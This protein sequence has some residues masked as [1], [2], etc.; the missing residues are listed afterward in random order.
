MESSGSSFGRV[1]EKLP[2]ISS[3]DKR[4]RDKPR[5]GF[6]VFVDTEK[7]VV[8]IKWV[9][10]SG[11]A[12][13]VPITNAGQGPTTFFG[14]MPEV[15]S[16]VSVGWLETSTGSDKF[17]PYI[18]KYWP[19]QA[20][21]GLRN[22]IVGA[23]NPDDAD[24]ET[25]RSMDK[26]FETKRYRRVRI[27]E[28]SVVASSSSGSDVIL[29]EDVGIQDSS[30]CELRIRASDKSVLM[31]S[32][33]KIT[34]TSGTYTKSGPVQRNSLLYAEDGQVTAT[35]QD[36]DG[37][38]VA[39]VNN[40]SILN[41]VVGGDG[42]QIQYVTANRMGVPGLSPVLTEHRTEL[43]RTNDLTIPVRG[44]LDVAE[45][46][47]NAPDIELVH[48]TVV[49]NDHRT[50]KGRK[51]YAR[52]LKPVLWDNDP[53]PGAA[54]PR[55]DPVN[56]LD[57]EEGETA[58]R[59]AAYL[60]RLKRDDGK[61]VLH[62]IDWEGKHFIHI[63][64]PSAAASG[65]SMDINA[66]GG[67]MATVGVDVESR[68]VGLRT[69]GSVE[70]SSGK[71]G[72]VGDSINL[73]G[74]GSININTIASKDGVGWRQ[75]TAGSVSTTVRG[76]VVESCSGSRTIEC[77]TLNFKASKVTY[78]S[79]NDQA[80]TVSGD[81]DRTVVGAVGDRIGGNRSTIIA[82]VN[83]TR[84]NPQAD[85]LRILLGNKETTLVAGAHMTNVTTGSVMTNVGAGPITETI[86]AGAYTI[87]V[88]TGS[89]SI[90]VGAGPITMTSGGPTAITSGGPATVTAPITTILSPQVLVG[91][92]A[93]FGGVLGG[94]KGVG[95]HLDYITGS[96]LRG[97]AIVR[98]AG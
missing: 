44:D 10:V 11:S 53:M 42:R 15:G 76:D 77:N 1:G 46:E 34:A 4:V 69:E 8:N 2:V 33:S 85:A 20:A 71:G 5:L 84:P 75:T 89:C 36:S 40:P 50:N 18:D 13:G 56:V 61:E 73:R 78:L 87:T 70:I 86:G 14:V 93:I 65:R 59:A 43:N 60:Y 26:L 47:E 62:A 52:A 3:H 66:E 81:D 39:E 31:S 72:G 90:T 38:T 98:I 63:P 54:S 67:I 45:M 24:P 32:S 88:G 91:T 92:G 22:E 35:L 16:V 30:G 17:K 64:K 51:V 12:I 37:A 7:Y 80:R 27:E 29:D 95:P 82:N 41:P 55:L 25:V 68:S 96:P 79:N 6:I 23:L 58:T 94:I 9:G 57:G 21:L 48:G 74:D 49:G 19:T 97:S 28:G 83:P